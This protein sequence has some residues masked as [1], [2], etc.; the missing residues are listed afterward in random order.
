MPNRAKIEI[1][2]LGKTYEDLPRSRTA[3]F[4]DVSLAIED[5]EFVSLVG[6]SGCGKSTLLLCVAGLEA[7]SHGEVRLEGKPVTRPGPDLAIVFQE[8][9]LF[10]WRTVMRN[11]E[12]GLEAAGIPARQRHERAKAM[13]VLVGLEGFE[14]YWPHELSGGMRQR[15]AIARALVTDPKVLLLDEPFG[16][17]DALTRSSLQKEL[18]R[19]CQATKKTVL[20]VTHSINEAVY[21]SDRIALL[22]KRP[23]TIR[24]E[25][26][27]GLKR[28]RDPYDA[29]FVALEEKLERMLLDEMPVQR[30]AAAA[31]L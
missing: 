3:V 2:R 30:N 23:A 17:L 8:Y 5:G 4:D 25:I 1:D 6:P 20:F 28:P 19:L 7:Q 21:L 18:S 24:L 31:A 29:E 10:P 12:Y 9:A 22:S 13:L 26:G 16:A 14:D 11:V 27:I 15:V